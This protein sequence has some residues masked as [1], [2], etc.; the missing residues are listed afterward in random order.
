MHKKNMHH[1]IKELT[2]VISLEAEK[3]GLIFVNG[4][5]TRAVALQHPSPRQTNGQERFVY[6]FGVAEPQEAAA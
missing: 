2:E 3:R 1:K 4:P 5:D 6:L